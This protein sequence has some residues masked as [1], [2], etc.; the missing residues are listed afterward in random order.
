MK[1]DEVAHQKYMEF[2]AD[3]VEE[4]TK[5]PRDSREWRCAS[6]TLETLVKLSTDYPAHFSE[7]SARVEPIGLMMEGAPGIGK[8]YLLTNMAKIISFY[9]K[10][11]EAF[12]MS[13]CT[14]QKPTGQYWEGYKGQLV[15]CMDDVFTKAPVAGEQES[16]AETVVKLI[17]QWPLSLNMANCALKGR[18]FMTS[19]YVLATTNM[20]DIEKL[21]K[22]V[23]DT[24]AITRRF[25]L[26]FTVQLNEGK[27]C[28]P[29]CS[30]DD[31]W[32]FY[33]KDHL[34]PDATCATKYNFTQVMT[35]LFKERKRRL[36]FF[37]ATLRN[38]DACK[39]LAD[40]IRGEIQLEPQGAALSVA[41]GAFC[42]GRKIAVG[43]GVA[44]GCAYAG[45]K[46]AIGV[47]RRGFKRDLSEAGGKIIAI[48]GKLM[49]YA[50]AAVLGLTLALRLVKSFKRKDN[51]V[52]PAKVEPQGRRDEVLELVQRNMFKIFCGGCF[53]GYGLGIDDMTLVVPNHFV[54]VAAERGA[55][56]VATSQSGHRVKLEKLVKQDFTTDQAYYRVKTQCKNLTSA[57]VSSAPG[58][59]RILIVF[60]D[61]VLK[62]ETTH[63]PVSCSYADY[64]GAPVRQRRLY[65]HTACLSV[66]DCG[67]VVMG[68]T[69]RFGR[70][71]FGMHT[72][73]TLDR[74]VK[75][76][77]RFSVF[78]TADC[79]P[80]G[81][82]FYQG[83][84]VIEILDYPV[85]NGG[86][87]R[88]EP[89]PYAGI[90]GE[91]KTA[92]SAKRPRDG[93]DPMV[94]AI[95]GYKRDW[96]PVPPEINACVDAVMAEIHTCIKDYNVSP[97]TDWEA[98]AGLQ[99]EPYSKGLARG[100]S[101]GYPFILKYK[102]KKAM[103]GAD[104]D[105]V[106]GP[107]WPELE[108]AVDKLRKIYKMGGKGAV[109]RDS[110]KDEP[111]TI[112]KVEAANTRMISGCAVEMCV[113]GRSQTLRYTSAL[114]QTRH[115]HG[116][117]PGFNP[118][119][120]EA[121]Q[122]YDR[123]AYMNSRQ[124][125]TAGDYKAFDKS[126]HPLI[127]KRI[128]DNIVSFLVTRGCDREV[129]DGLGRDT[130]CARHLGGNSYVSDIIYEV[131]GT[132][133]SGHWMTSLLNSMYNA[134][135]LRYCWVKYAGMR[136]IFDF[137]KYVA[138]VYYGD[139]FLMAVADQHAAFNLT[140][141]QERVVDLGLIMTDEEGNFGGEPSKHITDVTFLCRNFRV[142]EKGGVWMPLQLDSINDMFNWK[143]RST[144]IEDHTEA[145]VRASLME[146]A[147]H[148]FS[149]FV[150]YYDTARVL[151]DRLGLR[152]FECNVPVEAA[153]NHWR[154]VNMS[155]VPIWTPEDE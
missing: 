7:A 103:L 47:A 109:F 84:K 42:I 46:V 2:Y 24:K 107:A 73:G 56:L 70:R 81:A 112:E 120:L 41:T 14:F 59:K 115:D 101:P 53:C 4:I 69:G 148:P 137:R 1:L 77:G 55:T 106:K 154:V 152:L 71:V 125:V 141:L 85:H 19:P 50:A 110:L 131:E 34:H 98:A 97:V 33:A 25:P 96:A 78:K 108:G 111:R 17:N 99:G 87:T 82:D 62:A 36:E 13:R 67:A 144:T 135:V 66:G 142:D 91:V 39:E 26:W 44:A 116:M 27:T 105:Y 79:I 68:A 28:S 130:F 118:F 57:H 9:E 11:D 32:S 8:T 136:A 49:V 92:P 43:A 18:F 12:D 121:G 122:L 23:V 132:L 15:L 147:A 143:K 126:Q 31:T 38:D 80:Q 117:M 58:E 155:Y 20:T 22:A 6:K 83:H 113:L 119:S 10:P 133:P 138:A 114:M 35:M 145:I 40:G 5:W 129:L 72:A 88:L 48:T 153:Y 134:V 60:P 54:T 21:G 29:G 75:Y 102:D 3:C 127:M 64:K 45:T 89:T 37:N 139:D 151:G 65:S 86:D 123:L 30:L 94:K 16:D 150:R 149:T 93:I 128:W 52:T 124:H 146:A 95:A 100:K 140:L 74:E 61:R 90:M 104:G 76:A 63:E 51:K